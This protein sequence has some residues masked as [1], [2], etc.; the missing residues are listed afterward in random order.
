LGRTGVADDQVG[1]TY[2]RLAVG[3]DEEIER[4]ERSHDDGDFIIGVEL[5]PAGRQH[6]RS[7]VRIH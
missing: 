3:D 2:E 5:P 1:A 6:H 7:Q 4:L